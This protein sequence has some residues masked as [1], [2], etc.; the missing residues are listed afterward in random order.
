MPRGLAVLI[1]LCLAAMSVLAQ[2]RALGLPYIEQA[3]LARHHAVLSGTAPDPWAYR[4]F[5][6][7]VVAA[8]LRTADA[9]NL[10]RPA[11]VG[12]LT[13]RL[14][15]NIAVFSLALS[16]Y[17]RLG[18]TPQLQA[19][20]VV[21][22]AWSMSHALYNSD[23]SVNTYF[24]LIAYLIAALCVV[25]NRIWV[26][27]PIVLIA[28]FNRD[29]A[30]LIPMLAVA[31]L[32]ARVVHAPRSALDQVL[33]RKARRPIIVAA[34]GVL[35]FGTAYLGI[36]RVVGPAPW[37]WGHTGGT[38][39][40][41]WNLHDPN[42]YLYVPLTFSALPII[43]VWRWRQLPDLL[44]GLLLLLGPLWA[45]TLFLLVYVAESRLFLVPIALAFIPSVLVT[46]AEVPHSSGRIAQHAL[47]GHAPPDHE[48]R[49]AEWQGQ[50]AKQLFL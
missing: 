16:Y 33:D 42:V 46:T 38:T 8:V 15:Q 48:Q 4:L 45:T 36:R 3:Q 43:A 24:D 47:P 50:G 17:R 34:V 30:A 1:I 22:L 49:T 6:E 44:R 37:P 23:L 19:I 25:S 9:F 31:P 18:M 26:L 21:L 5:S 35:V 10:A 12:F 11:V 29:T 28:A 41:W 20:G 2:E 7:W 40:L 13:L 14:L 27:V 39:M 32:L